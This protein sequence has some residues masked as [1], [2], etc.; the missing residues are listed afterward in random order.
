MSRSFAL[1]V[2][3][4]FEAFAASGD[5]HHVT[6]R[7]GEPSA[8][9]KGFLRL[10]AIS[11][12]YAVRRSENPKRQ[13]PIEPAPYFARSAHVTGWVD[14]PR[15]IN[16]LPSLPGRTSTFTF[17]RLPMSVSTRYLPTKPVPPV[18]K[19]FMVSSSE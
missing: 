5:V 3:S 13:P 10:N 2:G 18:I 9:E 17:Q 11:R 4:G 15:V 6:T 8:P 14:G 16:P 19:I 1:I 7:F 12:C